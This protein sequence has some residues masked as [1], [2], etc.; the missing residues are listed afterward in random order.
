MKANQIRPLNLIGT[1]CEDART[2]QSDGRLEIT[3]GC[4]S[5]TPAVTLH[6]DRLDFSDYMGMSVWVE[7]FGDAE[8]TLYAM[9]NGNYWNHGFEIVRPGEIKPLTVLFIRP[10]Q[11]REMDRYFQ[12]MNG[13]PDGSMTLWNPIDPGNVRQIKIYLMAPDKEHRIRVH[14]VQPYRKLEVVTKEKLETGFFPFIDE[15]G[16][17]RHKDWPGKVHADHDLAKQRIA[18]AEDLR[19]NTGPGDWNRFGG[20][21]TGPKLKATGHFRVEKTGGKWWFV[22]PDGHLFWSH[23]VCCVRFDQATPFEGREHYFQAIPECK[24]FRI[25]NLKRKYGDG[26]EQTVRELSHRRLRSWGLNTL[27]NHSREDLCLM[28]KTPYTVSLETRSWQKREFPDIENPEWERNL[29]DRLK[30]LAAKVNGDPWCLGVFIDN[31]I[32]GSTDPLRWEKYFQTVSRLVKQA[33]PDKLYLG[34]RLDHHRYPHEGPEA[35]AIVRLAAKYCDVVSFNFYK[36]TLKDFVWLDGAEDKPAIIGEFH[37]GAPDRGLPHTGLK[38]AIS[39]R[40][41]AEAY[42]EYVQ[43]CLSKPQIVGAHWFQYSDQMYTGRFDGENY[44]IGF[45]DIC[46][47]PYEELIETSRSVGYRIYEYRF[48]S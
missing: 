38:G 31:E 30:K 34:C 23:G 48:D 12:G 10:G 7:N 32:H 4:Q 47:K 28:G 39:Q 6:V 11:S 45:V 35:D 43:S 21:R 37:I 18:E 9:L 17:Y 1:E 15:Y 36:Y 5:V 41:R 16:Q 40:H 25:A 29:K 20:W 27:A 14:G 24:D 19:L 44:Q 46:D 33:F 3:F 26:W 8:L 22:D 2:V 42:R 13:L